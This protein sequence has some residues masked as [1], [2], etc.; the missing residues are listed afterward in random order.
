MSAIAAVVT[1]SVT[2]FAA[3][4]IDDIVLLALFFGRGV[5]TRKIVT[6]QYL[7]FLAIILLSCAGLL[8][9]F[10][11]P[12]QWIRAL[13]LIPLALGLKQFIHVFRPQKQ[14]ESPAHRFGILSIGLITLSNGVDNVGV[15]IPFFSVN[16]NYLWLILVSF[17]VLVALLCMVGRWIGNHRIILKSVNRAGHLLVPFVFIGL[18]LYILLF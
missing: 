12:H 11:V 13:G 18:G 9:T 16:R 7:G 14:K 8:L 1:A 10:A 17:A 6:G 4:N 3:T 2:T 15:Y 5:P